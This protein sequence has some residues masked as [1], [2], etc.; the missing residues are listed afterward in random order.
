M[1]VLGHVGDFFYETLLI[2]N[3]WSLWDSVRDA[4]TTEM[5]SIHCQTD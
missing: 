3:R 4:L 2:S 5:V 1:V